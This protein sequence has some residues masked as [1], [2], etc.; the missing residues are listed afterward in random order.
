MSSNKD[1]KVSNF[2]IIVILAVTGGIFMYASTLLEGGMWWVL[3]VAVV[4]IL[5]LC[6]F[7][8]NRN[9]RKEQG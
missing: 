2:P 1:K 4:A 6:S 7:Q 9:R 5:V 8:I 3:V